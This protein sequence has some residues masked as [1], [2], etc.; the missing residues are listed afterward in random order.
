MAI[1]NSYPGITPTAE[2]LLLICDTSVEGNPTKTASVNSVLALIPSGSGGGGIANITSSNSTFLTVTNPDGPILTLNVQTGFVASGGNTLAT[3][4]DIYTFT[5]T[6]ITDAINALPTGVTSF[7][8][9][10]S[11]IPAFTSNVTTSSAGSTTLTISRTGGSANQFLDYTGNWSTPSVQ[12]MTDFEITADTGGSDKVVQ[13][14]KI[15]FVGKG[16]I[17][18]EFV[19][20]S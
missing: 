8:C 12:G 17:S 16:K 1:I 3:T 20:Q 9:D 2:D 11:N 15:N 10:I 14:D 18:T 4:G 7:A 13:G 5:T 6:Q 19:T